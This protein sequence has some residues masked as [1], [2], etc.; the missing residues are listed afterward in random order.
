MLSVN[1]R[2]EQLSRPSTSAFLS[3]PLEDRL[4]VW[5]SR[6]RQALRRKIRGE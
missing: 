3:L 5:G 2:L 6:R 1:R 4:A